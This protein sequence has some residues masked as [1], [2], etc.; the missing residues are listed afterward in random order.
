MAVPQSELE[1]EAN[2]DLEKL[3][4]AQSYYTMSESQAWKDLMERIK[5]L[6]D[7]AEQEFFSD[8]G[9]DPTTIIAG[10]LK[11]QQRMLAKQ[12]ILQ[13]VQGQLD[14][15]EVILEE[16]KGIDEHNTADPE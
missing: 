10:K 13:I 16:M 1:V 4:L 5:G 12:A 2:D 8:I 11:W 9:T 6:V 15:R 14:T 7:A 3:T